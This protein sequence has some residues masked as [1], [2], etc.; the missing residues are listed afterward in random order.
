[1]KLGSDDV[2][3]SC[4]EK[5]HVHSPY[6]LPVLESFRFASLAKQN[7]NYKDNAISNNAKGRTSILNIR[8]NSHKNVFL[9]L[10]K[11][12]NQRVGK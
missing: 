2:H 9:I 8:K 11:C 1:M 3:F 4:D 7:R 6:N 5:R 12:L 10:A